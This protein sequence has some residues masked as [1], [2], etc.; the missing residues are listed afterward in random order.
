[1]ISQIY[2]KQSDDD[3]SQEKLNSSD[4]D[5]G[6]CEEC[7]RAYA[8]DPEEEKM[9][10]MGCDTCDRWY[11]YSCLS[12]SSIPTGFWSVN[13]TLQTLKYWL[14]QEYIIRESV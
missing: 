5:N 9:K 6:V 7:G 2:S 1:M 14:K 12:L 4:E 11:H 13:N 3:L 10:W 8:D